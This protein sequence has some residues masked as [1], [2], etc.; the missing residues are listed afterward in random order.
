M[1]ERTDE[2]QVLKIIE[3]KEPPEKEELEEEALEIFDQIDGFD[4]KFFEDMTK[5][6]DIGE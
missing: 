3:K 4:E 2:K 5:E 6:K 1:I